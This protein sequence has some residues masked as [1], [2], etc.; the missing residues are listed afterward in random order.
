M[1]ECINSIVRQYINNTRSQ[2]SQELLNLIMFY[3]NHCRYKAGKREG[4]TPYEILTGEAQT[5]DWLDLLM[6]AYEEQQA[7]K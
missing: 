4:K 1:V 5:K 2:I 3:H 6:E 7:L